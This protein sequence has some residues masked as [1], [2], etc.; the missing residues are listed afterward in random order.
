MKFFSFDSIGDEP[1][2]ICRE[3][4]Q[5][6]RRVQEL[7][8]QLTQTDLQIQAQNKERENL[9]LQVNSLEKRILLF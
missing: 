8:R 7:D 4:D 2:F 1:C 9:L 3:R 6:E 5:F